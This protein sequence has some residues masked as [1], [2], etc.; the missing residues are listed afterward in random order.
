[1][2]L[3]YFTEQQYHPAWEEVNGPIRNT[4]PRGLID[5]DTAADLINRYYEGPSS[6]PVIVPI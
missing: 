4:A 6:E 5:P 3:W 1:M 2:K